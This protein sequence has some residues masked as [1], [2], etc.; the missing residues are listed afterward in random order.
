M[1]HGEL[2]LKCVQIDQTKKEAPIGDATNFPAILSWGLGYHR[3]ITGSKKIY[4][5][6]DE[7][8]DSL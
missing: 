3:L 2:N 4:S 6:P 1:E 5:H 7:E 8:M